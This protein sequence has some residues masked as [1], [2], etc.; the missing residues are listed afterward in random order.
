MTAHCSLPCYSSHLHL[1]FDK[2]IE[3]MLSPDLLTYLAGQGFTSLTLQTGATALDTRD[4]WSGDL[5]VETYQYK[6]SLAEVRHW[7]TGTV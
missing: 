5:S 2:L 6:P 1:Q 3:E 7:D 4:V